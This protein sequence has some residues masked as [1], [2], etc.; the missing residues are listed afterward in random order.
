MW[1]GS[2]WPEALLLV[3]LVGF[4]GWVFQAVYGF[5]QTRFFTVDEYQYGHATWLIGRG[6]LPYLDF[7]EHH[8]PLSYLLHAPFFGKVVDLPSAALRLRAIVF[9]YIFGASLLTALATHRVTRDRAAA[10]VAFFL[11][12]S[13][14]FSLMSAVDYRADCFAAYCWI[15]SLALLELN[16]VAARR[17]V[18]LASGLLLVAAMLMTQKL[19]FIGSVTAGCMLLRD[20][21]YRRADAWV[22]QPRWFIGTLI[23]ASAAALVAAWIS[24]TLVKGFQLT[25]L[26]ALAHE[27][28]YPDTS[29]ADY[30]RP[31]WDHTWPSSLAVLG[32]LAAY[33]FCG[34]RFWLVP[35]AIV[36]VAA[37]LMN[38][39]FPYNYVG[40][41]FIASIAAVRGLAVLVAGLRGRHFRAA[42]WLYLVAIP[43]ALSQ[44]SFVD[45]RA[46]NAH[47]LHLLDKL[48]R[49]SAPEDVVIDSAG[50][51]LFR[52]H[53]SYYWYHGA[54]HR[55]L[56]RRY[57]ANQLVDDYR[58]SR[59]IFWINDW[60]LWELPDS[61]KRYFAN[62]YIRADGHL[63]TLG[64]ETTATRDE[65]LSKVFEIIRS[66]SY[67][68]HR[69]TDQRK[70]VNSPAIAPRPGDLTIDS[71][72]VAGG[73]IQLSEGRHTL[74]QAPNSPG[75]RISFL[76]SEVFRGGVSTELGHSMLF[77]YPVPR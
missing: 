71:K 74:R 15:A 77:Q 30:V 62:H 21:L 12:I 14:G 26:D 63:F 73:S 28:L 16:Q 41:C 46:S 4:A 60:R 64:T 66:G 23:L 61:V 44:L 20:R 43:I 49:F 7:Y 11:P 59:A 76:S 56:Y 52:P 1:R 22:A 53:G 47:Q 25:V 69:R 13:F 57:F 42:S 17:G 5:G 34:G 33:A 3:I 35:L 51:A 70:L 55:Q 38:A 2:R 31:F 36:A 19:V 75:Y 18:A 37:G 8:L 10:L 72:P 58:R 48:G 9:A 54:A 39:Q 67:H 50:G 40:W 27:R 6:Q 65:P 32:L 24:G 68:V 45:G 29:L